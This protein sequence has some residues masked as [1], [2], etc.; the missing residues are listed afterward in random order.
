MKL[1]RSEPPSTE[2]PADDQSGGAAMPN[3]A[4]RVREWIDRASTKA[5]RADDQAGDTATPILA[6]VARALID[7]ASTG[8]VAND[9]SDTALP[10]LARGVRDLIERA[11]GA[12]DLTPKTD[13]GPSSPGLVVPVEPVDPAVALQTDAAESHGTPAI[14]TESV[15]PRRIAEGVAVSDIWEVVKGRIRRN[16][17]DLVRRQCPSPL[18]RHEPFRTGS[19][20][21]PFETELFSILEQGGRDLVRCEVEIASQ[22]SS[23]NLPF[24]EIVKISERTFSWLKELWFS[25]GKF[26]PL[27]HLLASD[28]L[29]SN[30]DSTLL[31]LENVLQ[32][33]AR[34]AAALPPDVEPEGEL[35][36]NT[37]RY[38]VEGSRSAASPTETGNT[39]SKGGYFQ[40]IATEA[41]DK[42]NIPHPADLGLLVPG[43]EE[44]KRVQELIEA[45]RKAEEA[46]P[47]STRWRQ[48][49]YAT[50][51]ASYDRRLGVP[52]AWRTI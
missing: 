19:P 44:D 16:V 6:G 14:N 34:S 30:I 39:L 28:G 1:H 40:G 43:T 20:S 33:A 48:K 12:R 8:T 11:A 22:R 45:S 23:G 46:N 4:H 25:A 24:V 38:V 10:N 42:P 3:L 49:W 29:D 35:P 31:R 15:P 9:Q 13:P 21:D 17:S 2:T 37:H 41:M 36:V 32:N 52:W 26:L 47:E 7:G 27:E 18:M 51:Q 5:L 50:L